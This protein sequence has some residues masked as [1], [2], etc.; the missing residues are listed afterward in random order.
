M[1]KILRTLKHRALS[2][3]MKTSM[4]IVLSMTR[5]QKFYPLLQFQM[6]KVCILIVLLYLSPLPLSNTD[7]ILITIDMLLRLFIRHLAC[8]N[9]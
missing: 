6:K 3:L 5:I 7:V 9:F 8:S 4:R 2:M 1:G